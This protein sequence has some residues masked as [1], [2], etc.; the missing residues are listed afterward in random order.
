MIVPSMRNI[1]FIERIYSII[2]RLKQEKTITKA[3]QLAVRI[4]ELAIYKP[5]WSSFLYDANLMGHTSN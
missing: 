2:E 3:S 1:N 5:G 4:I